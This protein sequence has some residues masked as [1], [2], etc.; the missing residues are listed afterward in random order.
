ML[1]ALGFLYIAAGLVRF[2]PAPTLWIWKMTVVTT[3]FGHFLAVP[4]LII[5][6]FTLTKHKPW[7][8]VIYMLA[9]LVLLT[10]SIESY[11]FGK[12]LNSQLVA[13]FGTRAELPSTSGFSFRKAFLPSDAQSV[14]PRKVSFTRPD[15]SLGL[16]YFYGATGSST[17]AAPLVISIHGGSWNSG[18]PLQLPELNSVLAHAGYA[19]AA[20]NYRFIESSPWPAQKNDVLAGVAWIRAHASEYSIDPNQLVILGRSAGGQIAET[21]AFDPPEELKPAVRGCIS[22]YAPADMNFAYKFGTEDDLLKSLALVRSFL[23][24]TPDQMQ[25]N[26]HTASGYDFVGSST[27]P[28]LLLHGLNDQL[29]WYRQS[30]RLRDKMKAAHRAVLLLEF[31]WAT[32]GFDYN[33]NGPSGQ[34]STEAILAFMSSVTRL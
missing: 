15:G 4:A 26:Y 10:P 31:P 1:I 9:A 2:L 32:H 29:V 13:T 5:A 30:E 14:T 11:F 19:V 21:V 6:I 25:N 20:I 18:D 22:F 17:Q 23:G 16:F 8:F 33:I 27:P 34:L 7:A 3:E 28:T 12:T 24:G